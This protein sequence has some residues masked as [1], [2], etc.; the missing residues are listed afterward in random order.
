MFI[1]VYM[2]IH[3]YLYI[4]IYIHTPTK[5]NS[6][7]I[8]INKQVSI[9]PNKQ[10]W[11]RIHINIYVYIDIYIYNN[12]IYIY[13]L[14]IYIYRCTS[15]SQQTRWRPLEHNRHFSTGH[16]VNVYINIYIYMHVYTYWMFLLMRSALNL[17]FVE[18]R[19][20][21]HSLDRGCLV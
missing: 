12:S 16:Y 8:Y 15:S 20:N 1:H 10:V 9:H 4:H 14:Y 3:I 7:R 13:R 6:I 5:Q 18:K 19:S 17:C 2:Y 21:T 11:I